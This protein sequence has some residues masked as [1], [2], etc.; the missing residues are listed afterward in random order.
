MWL[1]KQNIN[2]MRSVPNHP[3][4]Q[5]KIERWHQTM[6]YLTLLENCLSSGDLKAKTGAFGD[7]DVHGLSN[8]AHLA[9]R[10]RSE[11]TPRKYRRLQLFRMRSHHVQD[12][13]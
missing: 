11:R 7:G 2:H 6:M 3:M 10:D 12:D 4:T 1:D 13:E 9:K 8:A 5:G